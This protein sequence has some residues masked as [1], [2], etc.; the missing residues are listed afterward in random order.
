MFYVIK[1]GI[2]KTISSLYVEREERES[3]SLAGKAV[4]ADISKRKQV[5]REER[6]LCF[7]GDEKGAQPRSEVREP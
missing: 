7:T 6:T 5:G 3:M 4:I 1:K 2:K